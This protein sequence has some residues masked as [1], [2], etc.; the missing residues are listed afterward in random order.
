MGKTAEPGKE[1]DITKENVLRTC[2]GLAAL[3]TAVPGTSVAQPCSCWP[4]APSLSDAPAWQGPAVLGKSV[5]QPFCA[6]GQ[7]RA[8]SHLKD[9]DTS[10]SASGP[11]LALQSQGRDQPLTS[12][13]V[14]D[15]RER[16]V[17]LESKVA[18]V[19]LI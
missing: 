11:P 4:L 2:W 19:L 1:S 18:S 6:A 13:H 9:W 14:R 17:S 16:L 3:W 8:R 15:V 12:C 7:I 10:H 5:A